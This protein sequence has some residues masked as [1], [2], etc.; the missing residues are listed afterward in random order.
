M[1]KLLNL[2]KYTGKWPNLFGYM[3][4]SAWIYGKINGHGCNGHISSCID[5]IAMD[6][7]LAQPFSEIDLVSKH[8]PDNVLMLILCVRINEFDM[9]YIYLTVIFFVK[10]CG[11]SY[12]TCSCCTF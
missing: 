12:C 4:K 6:N 1:A 8:G 2:S 11:I 9:A 5:D 7:V 10:L 3:P